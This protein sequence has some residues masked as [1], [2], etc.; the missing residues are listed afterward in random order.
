MKA[1]AEFVT[2][3]HDG[4]AGIE[5]KIYA[6]EDEFGNRVTRNQALHAS[7]MEEVNDT[8]IGNV[9]SA[10]PTIQSI[11]GAWVIQQT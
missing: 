2:Y 5:T 3:A 10:P 6:K 1:L 7:G 11:V 9:Q 4:E 8:T